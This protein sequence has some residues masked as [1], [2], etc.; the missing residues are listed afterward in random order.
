MPLEHPQKHG[1]L[2]LH[3]KRLEL[4][5]TPIQF[6][7]FCNLFISNQG[8]LKPFEGIFNGL[9][10]LFNRILVPPYVLNLFYE[11]SYFFCDFSTS[12]FI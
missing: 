10:I 1:Y 9:K 5:H 3:I 6:G 7:S 12:G 2:T 8:F 11:D 4:P